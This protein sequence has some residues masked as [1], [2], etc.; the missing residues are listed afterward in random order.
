MMMSFWDKARQWLAQQAVGQERTSRRAMV[1]ALGMYIPSEAD[2]IAV[3]FA[4]S[5]QPRPSGPVQPSPPASPPVRVVINPGHALNAPGAQ[6]PHINEAEVTGP[7]GRR[8]VEH[9]DHRVS[10]EWVRQRG[11]G[12]GDVQRDLQANS[13]PITLSIHFDSGSTDSRAVKVI[14]RGNDPDPVRRANAQRL[15][16][17]LGAALVQGGPYDEYAVIG[18]P[19]PRVRHS[20]LAILQDTATGA[21]V[22]VEAG[23][24]TNPAIEAF[25]RTQEGQQWIADALDQGI[26][27]YLDSP[28]QTPSSASAP[29]SPESAG[30]GAP[31]TATGPETARGRGAPGQAPRGA[32]RAPARLR[33]ARGRTDQ[34]RR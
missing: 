5:R 14:Y 1:E 32:R 29:G 6:G 4:R 28:Q 10:Y 3:R 22:L 33:P 21:A 23:F 13:P 24:I 15:G 26:R 16:E 19:D 31:A 7:V 12:L 20:R 9:S 18:I 11:T 25:A 27:S 17:S 30:R 8:I 2:E 34:R